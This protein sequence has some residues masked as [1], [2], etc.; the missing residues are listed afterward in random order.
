VEILLPGNEDY[1]RGQERLF[2]MLLLQGI[3]ILMQELLIGS[4]YL[5]TRVISI[6]KNSNKCHCVRYL[7]LLFGADG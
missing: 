6:Q 2:I 1:Y 4:I 3:D 7:L 5:K